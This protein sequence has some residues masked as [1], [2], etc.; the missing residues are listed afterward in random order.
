MCAEIQILGEVRVASPELAQSL[1]ALYPSI[2]DHACHSN[3]EGS[4]G[5]RIVGA[6]LP[7]VVE[8]LS[9]DILVKRFAGTESPVFAGA[10][11]PIFAGATRWLD[12][13]NSLMQVRVG[14]TSHEPSFYFDATEAALIEA[15]HL[16]NTLLDAE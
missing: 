13:D 12:R 11:S 2:V 7:H 4:F 15:V 14:C 10:Q 3:G 16:M 9:I 5:D 1:I 8:H 6:L